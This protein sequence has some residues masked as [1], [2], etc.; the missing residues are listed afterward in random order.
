MAR[1]WWR[2]AECPQDKPFYMDPLMQI[3]MKNW[4]KDRV[5]LTGDAVHSLTLLSGQGASSAFWGASTLSRA[6]IEYE[7]EQAFQIYQNELQPVIARIQPSVRKAAK[8]YIPG[9]TLPYL[10]RDTLMTCLPNLFFQ[11]YFKHKYTSA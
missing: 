5:V 7:P 3:S 2:E 4:Y 8:W 9:A 10:V 1:R 11:K 6:L